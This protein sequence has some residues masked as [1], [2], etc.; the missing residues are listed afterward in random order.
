[1]KRISDIFIVPDA[2]DGI[3]NLSQRGLCVRPSV[4]GTTVLQVLELVE[5]WLLFLTLEKSLNHVSSTFWVASEEHFMHICEKSN[6]LFLDKQSC[7]I[8]HACV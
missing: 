6:I 1:M 3:Q 2:A 8:D 7:K 5:C 4:A